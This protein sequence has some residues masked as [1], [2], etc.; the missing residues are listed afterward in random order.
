MS[1]KKL[2]AEFP[3]VPTEKWE[4]V[5]QADLKGA[6]YDKKLVWRTREGFS[7]R[8]YYRSEHLEDVKYLGSLPGEFPFVRGSQTS[9]NRWEIRQDIV[10][11]QES[12]A[13]AQ[14]HDA[15]E[16]GADAVGFIWAGNDT[17]KRVDVPALVEGISLSR[18]AVHFDVGV[19]APYVLESFVSLAASQGA[20]S[21]RG[22]VFFDP[23]GQLAVCGCYYGSKEFPLDTL[24]RLMD[25]AADRPDVK[26]IGANAGWFQNAGA[27]LVQ[28]L[29][30]GLSMGAEYL[31]VLTDAGYDAG[32]V[33]SS[34]MFRFSAGSNYFMEIAKLRAARLLWAHLVKAWGPCCEECCAMYIHAETARWNMTKYDPCVNMLRTTTETMSAVLGGADSITVLPYDVAFRDPEAFSRRIARNQQI[35]IREEAHLGRIVDPAGG[36]YYIES[37][38]R[39]LADA[40]WKLFLE[41]EEQG[42]YS[43][44]MKQGW[45]QSRVEEAAAKRSAAL[46]TRKEVLLGTNQYASYTERI[47]EH[48]SGNA[49]S[50]S[51]CSCAQIV[52]PVA[53]LRLAEGFEELRLRTERS[54]K[55]P[56]VFML[57]IGNLAM[58]KARAGFACNF[59]AVAG[60]EVLDNNG[61]ETLED[62]VEEA[63]QAGA[64]IIVLCSSD[65]EYPVLAPRAVELT[66]GKA[67]FV[68][69]GYPKAIVEDLKAAGVEHFIYAGQNVLEALQEYQKMLGL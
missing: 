53:P 28:E 48:L 1:E 47:A 30:L 27:T 6:D 3:P 10:V 46:A 37:L 25:V 34:M 24:K 59:F 66:R 55:T 9:G 61:F 8:P 17:H 45:I 4:E 65:D 57:T 64:D 43:Q 31:S 44:A 63:L 12:D 29:A 58:R 50:A 20:A 26:V 40:A 16:K 49:P 68:L 41:I 21:P 62:G 14:A 11:E 56:R 52:R 54:G 35:V 19:H 51:A 32:K 22:S 60:F 5:I 7:V 36:S 15:L 18:N 33:S 42:G 38:T 69:A 23:L 13:R 39:S 2:F 67:L